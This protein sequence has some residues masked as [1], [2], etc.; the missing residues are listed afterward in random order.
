MLYNTYRAKN[1]QYIP[2][3][4]AQLKKEQQKNKI[5][6]FLSLALI[7]ICIAYPIAQASSRSR[8]IMDTT[9]R[10]ALRPHSYT[11]SSP[12]ST[13]RITWQL[14]TTSTSSLDDMAHI[15]NTNTNS[16]TI[17]PTTPTTNNT[18]NQNTQTDKNQIQVPRNSTVTAR[19]SRYSI[20]DS[21]HYPSPRGCLMANGQPVYEGALACPRSLPFGTKVKINGKIHTCTDRYALWLDPKF[22]VPTFDIFTFGKAEGAPINTVEVL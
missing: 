16:K 12:T 6:L 3:T 5:A 13:P 22:K 1:G 2:L 4:S 17:K 19:V 18:Y 20:K 8:A 15:L 9:T 10:E 21:C 7:Y 11:Y 14:G